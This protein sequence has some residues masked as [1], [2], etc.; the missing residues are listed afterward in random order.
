MA[1]FQPFYSSVYQYGVLYFCHSFT[2]TFGVRRLVALFVNSASLKSYLLVVSI[3]FMQIFFTIFPLSVSIL[4]YV[5]EIKEAQI[6]FNSIDIHPGITFCDR[7]AEKRSLS[8]CKY[9]KTKGFTFYK[10][11]NVSFCLDWFCV[12]PNQFSLSPFL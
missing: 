1:A 10:R 11:R 9:L 2:V 8:L 5:E 6:G 12:I 7:K 3:K 4:L